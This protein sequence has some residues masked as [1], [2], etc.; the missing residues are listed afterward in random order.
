M[1]PIKN[2]HKS[3][4]NISSALA[5]GYAGFV[6]GSILEMQADMFEIQKSYEEEMDRIQELLAELMGNDLAFNPMSLTDASRGNGSGT[7]GY[8]PE[9]LDDF[10]QRTTLTGSDIVEMTLSV[11]TD[12]ADLSLTLPKT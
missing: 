8:L 10:I 6:R 1:S 3:I 9:S 4:W 5:N 7:G 12:F 11:I 2:L